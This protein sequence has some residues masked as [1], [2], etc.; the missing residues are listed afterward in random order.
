MP[1]FRSSIRQVVASFN[2]ARRVHGSMPAALELVKPAIH[3]RAEEALRQ[4]DPGGMLLVVSLIHLLFDC[5]REAVPEEVAD[6]ALA[7]LEGNLEAAALQGLGLQGAA[8]AFDRGREEPTGTLLR[9]EVFKKVFAEKYGLSADSPADEERLWQLLVSGGLEV[10]AEDLPLGNGRMWFTEEK[11]LKQACPP[12]GPEEVLDGS[13]AYD[14]LGLDW[15][16]GWEEYDDEGRARCRAVLISAL[17]R[18]RGEAPGTLRIPTGIDG[19]LF[20]P[21]VPRPEARSGPWPA[22][23]GFTV[24]PTTGIPCHPEGVHGPGLVPR[25]E[26]CPARACGEV[27]KEVPDRTAECGELI[28]RRALARLETLRPIP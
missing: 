13:K 20:L 24:D 27:V 12:R 11:G 15:S 21:F 17:L 4:R 28:V 26:R 10:L 3:A 23:A 1:D 19:W 22:V 16:N 25:S 8:L 9:F 18:H 6:R 5:C 14:R 7:A 2:A